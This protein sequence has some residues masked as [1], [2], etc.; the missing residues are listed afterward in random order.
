MFKAKKLA[1]DPTTKNEE[2][3]AELA[4][5]EFLSS[6]EEDNDGEEI[7]NVSSPAL[8]VLFNW[9]FSDFLHFLKKFHSTTDSR[10]R[11][12]HAS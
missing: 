7:K 10:V 1:K 11:K 9:Y 2:K 4:G 3:Q 8:R 12:C 5:W 6:D